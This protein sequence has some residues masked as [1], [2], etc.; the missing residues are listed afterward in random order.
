MIASHTAEIT[1]LYRYPIKGLT[2]E[3]LPRVTLRRGETLP[4]DRRY[5]IENGPSGF[6]PEA[7]EWK[8]KIQ[9]LM[10]ARNER[11]AALD[12]RFDDETNVLTIRKDGQIVACG[13]LETAAG[14]AAIEA[15]FR[16]NFQPELKGPPKLLSGRDHSFSDVARKVVSIINLGS[17]RAI[18]T[19]LG[20][21]P[22]HPLR[23]RANLYVKGWTAWSELDLVGQTLAIGQARLKVIK[24]IV[25]CPA[26]NV[27]PETA[28]RDL[29]IPPTLS[30]H[31]G[32]MDC[33]IYAEV[34]ADGDVGVGDVVA[35][36]EPRLI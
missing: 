30:R 27:D 5:A 11:L 3:A 16:D 19:M 23:F 2:P 18:E 34:I 7:P 35:V 9:F 28:R 32:H 24:R 36:E 4:A 10:L 1:G 12:S 13:D 8:P 31:L 33:G 20:G 26:T 29:E 15:Y 14:R 6:D 22:V 17:V 21:V 25:R